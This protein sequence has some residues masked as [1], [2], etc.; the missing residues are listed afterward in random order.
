MYCFRLRRG[1][2]EMIE[3]H[4]AEFADDRTAC[5]EAMRTAKEIALDRAVNGADLALINFQIAHPNGWV[6]DTIPLES[7]VRTN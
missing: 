3:E 1:E 2:S 4:G 6:L 5:V 7:L